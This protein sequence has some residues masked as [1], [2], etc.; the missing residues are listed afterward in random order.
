MTGRDVRYG[1]RGGRVV[2]WQQPVE[3]LVVRVTCACPSVKF[4]M[5]VA[6]DVGKACWTCGEELVPAE[7]AA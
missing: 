2:A 3:G 4:W 1:R 5:V 7:V 6:G